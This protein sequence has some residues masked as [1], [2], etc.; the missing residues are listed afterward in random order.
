[1]V[2]GL[3]FRSLLLL[4]KAK[5]EELVG[6]RR[7]GRE[8]EGALRLAHAAEKSRITALGRRSV[9]VWSGRRGRSTSYSSLWTTGTPSSPRGFPGGGGAAL[10]ERGGSD[11]TIDPTRTRRTGHRCRLGH[12]LVLWRGTTR[13]FQRGA[14]GD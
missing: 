14:G 7:V 2:A 3:T 11:R 12:L 13:A 10:P 1:M 5:T 8:L 4:A 6:D 9:Q